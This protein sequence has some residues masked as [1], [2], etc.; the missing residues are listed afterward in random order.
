[1]PGTT[2]NTRLINARA[3]KIY[4]ALTD[5]GLL[6]QWQVPGNMKAVLHSFELREGGGYSMSLFYPEAQPAVP[7]KT[8]ANEDRFY[9][10]FTRL[11][12]DRSITEAI[13]FEMPGAALSEEMILQID[14][15]PVNGGMTEVTFL[16]TNIPAGIRPED[17]EAGTA[18]SL[19]K[20]ARLV[21]C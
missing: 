21:E 3:G 16:F 13:R 6:V 10:R 4:R 11:I 8:A 18:S 2:K 7:G 1:M 14:L 15:I 20:L 19:E 5:P 12:P 9:A 17:N